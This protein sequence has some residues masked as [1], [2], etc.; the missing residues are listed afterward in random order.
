VHPAV[1]SVA[2]SHDHCFD[3]VPPRSWTYAS[4]VLK[5]LTPQELLNARLVRSM[6]VGYLAPAWVEVLLDAIGSWQG[7]SGLDVAGL[8][9]DYHKNPKLQKLVRDHLAEGR[10]DRLEEIAQRLRSILEG[11]ELAALVGRKA[12]SL[13]AF[14]GL[15]ADL[16]GD[17]RE[18][19]QDL[20]L[21]NRAS[22]LLA[23]IPPE[24]LLRGYDSGPMAKRVDAWLAEPAKEYRVRL[25]VK[26][27]S[28][29][30][31]EKADLIQLRKSMGD[32]IGLGHFVAQL[33]PNRSGPLRETFERCS[34][35]PILPGKRRKPR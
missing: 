27:L 30:L 12:F 2:R 14:D 11:P 10:T 7:E 31:E 22:A 35:E 15:T 20:L 29:H 8:L 13:D 19:L 25:L 18:Q 28:L 6:L 34:I 23:E 9:A 21:E 1:L 17:H 26:A 3:D 4:E 5:V 24:H 16:P 32:L 33:G